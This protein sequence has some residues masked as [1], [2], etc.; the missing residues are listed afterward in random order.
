M[1]NERALQKGRR[2]AWGLLVL[3]LPLIS[4][5]QENWELK[6]DENGIAAYSRKL[7]NGRYKEIKVLCE[8]R[9][10]AEQLMAALKDID[11]QKDWSYATKSA[12]IINRK[13]NGD[14]L[15]YAEIALPWPVSNRD[16]V[17]DLSFRRDSLSRQIHIRAS[18]VPGALPEKKHLVRIPFSL[19]E[20]TVTPLV[21][22][23]VA[24]VYT[25]SANPGGELPAWLVNMAA[26]TGP[27]QS[28]LK[29][30]RMLEK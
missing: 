17:I 13:P 16:V 23:R 9:C 7:D 30:K 11:H 25:F 22:N 20:W 6:R 1:K 27:Y 12:S 24:I 14:L 2:L 5:G 28:F 3:A 10:T 18:S 8:I 21:G 15:Y 4:R 19:A 29:L 26:S